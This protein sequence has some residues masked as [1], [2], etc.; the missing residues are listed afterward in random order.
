MREAVVDVGERGIVISGPMVVPWD[1][2]PE[3]LAAISSAAAR[4][5]EGMLE[6]PGDEDEHRTYREI[7]GLFRLVREASNRVAEE[8]NK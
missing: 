5:L 3:F 1:E 8:L 4:V 7:L 2:V 6:R